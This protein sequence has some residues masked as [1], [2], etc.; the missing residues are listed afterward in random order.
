M[1]ANNGGLIVVVQVV[2]KVAWTCCTMVFVLLMRH[3]KEM[4]SNYPKES[5][6]PLKSDN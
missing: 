5:S 2:G 6:L 4:A 3:I 1:N